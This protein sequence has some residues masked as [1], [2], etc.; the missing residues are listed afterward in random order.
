MVAGAQRR[1][2]GPGPGSAVIMARSAR[3][4]IGPS[5]VGSLV[6]PNSVRV[7]VI[8]AAVEPQPGV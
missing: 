2:D 1:A 5:T 6:A 3:S 4:A 7:G 8:Y